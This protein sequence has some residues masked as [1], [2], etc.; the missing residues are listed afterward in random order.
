[1]AFFS[2]TNV[3]IKILHNLALFR[4]K[5]ANFFAEIFGENISK[6]HNVG[7][8]STRPTRVQG[9]CNIWYLG[10]DE[11]LQQNL[12]AIETV[13]RHRSPSFRIVLPESVHPWECNKS[14]QQSK[15]SFGKLGRLRPILNFA[16]GANFDPRGGIVPWG[17]TSPDIKQ[18]LT[19]SCHPYGGI[20]LYRWQQKTYLHI[21]W[22]YLLGVYFIRKNFLNFIAI[23]GLQKSCFHLL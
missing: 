4:V 11:L 21:D 8:C 6:N 17:W 13:K 7:P 19:I 14:K 15:I 22:W 3:M 2:K 16:L 1:L 5:N 20:G 12:I 18:N 10:Q 9:H 23:L